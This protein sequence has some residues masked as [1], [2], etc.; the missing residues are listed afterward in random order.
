[1]KKVLAGF[2]AFFVSMS[3][4]I[5][6]A[7]EEELSLVRGNIEMYG[8]AKLSVDFIK[9]GAHTP[10][11]TKLYKVSS[12][13]SRFGLKGSEDLGNGLSAIVQVELGI[14]MDG[15]TSSVVSSVTTS[16][17]S[18]TSTK[19]TDENTISFRNTFAG[20]RSEM[21][22]T[23]LLGTYDTPY[24]ISTSKLDPFLETMGDYNSIISS[25]NGKVNFD[26]RF[27]DTVVYL[28]PLWGG[29]QLMAS[30]STTGME[31]NNGATGNPSAY[32]A[33]AAYT[34]GLLY[35]SLA[36][37]IHK[38][39]FT[40]GDKSGRMKNT[41]AKAGLGFTAGDTKIGLV[42]ESLKDGTVDSVNSRDAYYVAVS[43]TIGQETIKLGY[44][45]A[46][47]GKDP[48]TKTGATLAVIGA[49]HAFSKRTTVYVLYAAVKNDADATYGIGTGG[50]GGAYVPGAGEEPAVF[51]IGLNHGF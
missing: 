19:T 29:L 51:S 44:G 23:L 32:S 49:D 48:S 27:K 2:V 41:G 37:E 4:S 24:K 1:M 50:A 11:D 7:A 34:A 10:A 12:N 36:Y 5:V 14:N 18:V 6:F 38:N 45:F 35:A 20:L 47:D 13:S 33:S 31:T 25:V 15:T 39:G 21:W 40:D 17:G 9:T 3:V 43:H 8:M 30:A 42:Y 22:G 16:G 26:L 28:S 46:A